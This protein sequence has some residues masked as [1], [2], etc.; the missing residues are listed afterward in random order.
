MKQMMPLLYLPAGNILLNNTQDSSILESDFIRALLTINDHNV[1]GYL[2]RQ[3]TDKSS[4][5][6]G[7]FANA[8]GI[9]TAGGV[10]SVLKQLAAAF[11][12]DASS[13]YL[14]EAVLN[15][16]EM[17]AF[18]L[19][20]LQHEDGTIDLITTNFHSPPDTA[21]VT[22]NV[23]LAYA[24]LDGMDE[25]PARL[26]SDLKKFLLNAGHAM[27]I[28]GI[29]TPNHRWVICM[30]LARINSL[31]P[32]PR[33]LKRIN[34][35]LA[36]GI[37][38]NEDGEYTE[39][40]NGYSALTN[41]CLITM[42]KLLERPQLFAPVRKNLNLNLFYLH[43]NNE[44]VTEISKRQDRNIQTDLT[45]FL[46]PYAYMAFKDDNAHYAWVVDWIQRNKRHSSL[47][48]YLPFL[49]EDAVLSQPLNNIKAPNRNYFHFFQDTDLVRIGSE[50]QDVSILHDNHV[51]FTLHKSNA[52]LQGIRMASA[53]FGKGQFKSHD[54]QVEN[55]TITLAQ[56]LEAPYYQP[57]PPEDI[58]GDGNWH[59]MPRE[60]RARSEVQFLE[61][62][63]SISKLKNGFQLEFQIL[64]T[65]NVPVAI[66]IA[67]R[68]GGQLKGVEMVSG[69]S[70][71][72]LF[73]DQ[74]LEYS[75]DGQK[76]LVEGG[77]TDHSWTNLRGALPKLDAMSAYVTGITPF[78]HTLKI[79]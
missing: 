49:L 9:Y 55:E 21:F 71:A 38:I 17:G 37:D 1:P 46:I 60:N 72:F 74:Q 8:Y 73:T 67:F 36:E 48:G 59:K 75:F 22:E 79:R 19:I 47:V 70:N 57:F 18:E 31:F 54:I 65:D 43:T 11:T 50:F 27:S 28:G 64:G 61:S 52:V 30:A 24:L 66:E 69:I 2:D 14:D 23:A 53:F 33:F 4:G 16:M 40:S 29:H 39:R 51:F 12:N 5:H 26:L 63:I 13:F 56:E 41:R 45:R 6:Y 7:G 15:S 32:D 62:K 10:A 20:N 78:T 76:I 77:R 68:K 35:W 42:A 44:V 25:P 58:T 34:E 3:Q